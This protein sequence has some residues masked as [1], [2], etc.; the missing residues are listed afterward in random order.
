L[1]GGGQWN[2]NNIDPRAK[3]SRKDVVNIALS[4]PQGLAIATR[5]AKIKMPV[6]DFDTGFASSRLLFKPTGHP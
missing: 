3:L 4:R 2:V 6:L 1:H 5:N